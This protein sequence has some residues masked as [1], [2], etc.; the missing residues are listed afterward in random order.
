MRPGPPDVAV[1]GTLGWQPVVSAWRAGVLLA[2]SIPVA[3]GRLVRSTTTDV[4]ERLTLRV[5]RWASVVPGEPVVD[6][7]PSAPDSPLSRYGVELDVSILASSAVDAR[8]WLVRQARVRVQEWREDDDEVEVTGEGVMTRLVES[9]LTS[10][11]QPSGSLV[12]EARRLLLPGMGLGVGAG[13]TDRACP[14]GMAW[15]GTRLDALTEIA[16][17][18]PARLRC[19]EWGQVQLLPPLPDVPTPVLTL[20]DGVG[21]TVVG[22]P[23]SDTRRGAYNEVVARS[24]ASGVEGVQAVAQQTTGPLAVDV[25]SPVTREW[26]SPLLW[27]QAQAQAAAETMLA[28]SLRPAATLPVTCAPDPRIDLDD[29]VA[30]VRDGVRTWGWVT[31]VDLPLTVGDG[32]MR[33]DVSISGG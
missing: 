30:V 6:W 27:S 1:A 7:L 18:W 25:Y 23:R 22:A 16:T 28:D 20:T 5:P 3:G 29:P 32:D 10:P 15:S 19:D 31:G 24:S 12:S 17:A 2:A 26:S 13:L 9:R 14:A 21:G 4:P 11:V 33:L 8:S